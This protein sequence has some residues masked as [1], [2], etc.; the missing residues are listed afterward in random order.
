MLMKYEHPAL[1]KHFFKSFIY[2]GCFLIKDHVLS[3]LYLIL[4]LYPPSLLLFLVLLIN[5]DIILHIN[6]NF[7]HSK[8][9]LNKDH[10][11]LH[12]M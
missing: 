6:T 8:V 12:T 5:Y 2:P 1:E 9:F 10:Y 3:I 11:Y 4:Y 7:N